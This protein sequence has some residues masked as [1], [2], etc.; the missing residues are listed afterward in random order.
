VCP[1]CFSPGN[2]IGMPI[3]IEGK[4]VS[5]GP[6]RRGGV[7]PAASLTRGSPPYPY[8]EPYAS[9][10]LG[11]PHRLLLA[12]PPGSGKTTLA[13]A[14]AVSAARSVSVL[15]VA[16]EQGHSALLGGLLRRIGLDDLTARRLQVSDARTSMEV[17]D[18]LTRGKYQLVVLDSVSEGDLTP[19]YTVSLL[20]D[21]SWIA[22][23]HV[24]TRGLPLGGHAWGHAV[25]AVVW[26]DGGVATPRK[27]R[28]GAMH[29]IP[30]RWDT[31]DGEQHDDEPILHVPRMRDEGA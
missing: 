20:G 7:V 19:E 29:A 16:I 3:S 6:R 26:C 22:V 18:D 12:G 27:N 30:I 24:N 2:L 21:R 11:T 9:W 17:E 1:G 4:A 13:A 31:T 8:G 15:Y 23:A 25:D 28:W 5:V 10:R 14:L